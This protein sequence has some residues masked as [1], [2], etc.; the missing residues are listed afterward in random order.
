[1]LGFRLDTN[2][3]DMEADPKYVQILKSKLGFGDVKTVTTPGMN[4][5]MDNSPFSG[6]DFTVQ[7]YICIHQKTCKNHDVRYHF[8]H[9]KID[10]YIWRN[11]E[12]QQFDIWKVA[13]PG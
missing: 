11:E 4:C 2:M 1:M 3:Q 8:P 10:I 5:S 13:K 9:D 6:R 12:L 7:E